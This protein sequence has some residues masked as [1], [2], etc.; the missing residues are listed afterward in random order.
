ML[1]PPSFPYSRTSWADFVQRGARS[2]PSPSRPYHALPHVESRCEAPLAPCSLLRWS[3]LLTT[4]RGLASRDWA[5]SWAGIISGS[6]KISSKMSPLTPHLWRR[7]VVRAARLPVLP[8]RL[9]EALSSKAPGCFPI[10][11]VGLVSRRER[12]HPSTSHLCTILGL[13]CQHVEVAARSTPHRG[14]P[15]LR[16]SLAVRPLFTA[17]GTTRAR[18]APASDPTTPVAC[19]SSLSGK[20]D[21]N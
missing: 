8:S 3:I 21:N 19:V 12:C 11:A 1:T 14:R 5:N 13:A 2:R 18:C 17:V 15:A 4:R 7:S 20:S 9:P 10:R 16:E 6:S